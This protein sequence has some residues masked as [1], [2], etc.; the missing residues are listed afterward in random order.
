MHRDLV[1]WSMRSYHKHIHK[2]IRLV[3]LIWAVSLVGCQRQ[4]QRARH[5]SE[6]R[7][8][9]SITMAKLQFNQQMSQAADR[10]CLEIANADTLQYAIDDFGFWYSKT[11][12]TDLD[13]VH[14]GDT[15]ELHIRISEIGGKM[16]SDTKSNFVVR[17]GEL[18]LAI[19]RSL[20]MMRKGEQM[21]IICPWYT[22]YGVEG[23][24]IIAPYSNLFIILKVE[25]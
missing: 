3:I 1:I 20:K 9:D 22:A 13:S 24:N 25:Q 6:E 14:K 23:T 18:P 21:H 7:D 17:S 4:P 10:L 11:I 16:I 8:V 19:V 15:V 2:A 12:I 5:L